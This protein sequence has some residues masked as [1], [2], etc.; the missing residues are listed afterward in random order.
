[1]FASSREDFMTVALMPNV[2]NDFIIGRVEHMVQRNGQLNRPQITGQ[3]PTSLC[4]RFKN[5]TTQLLR[6]L[7]QLFTR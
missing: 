1:M 4:N 7:T 6:E 3:M 2:P 5:K